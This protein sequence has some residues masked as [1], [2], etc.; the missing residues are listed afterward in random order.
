MKYKCSGVMISSHL[1]ILVTCER[2][3]A[4][5]RLKHYWAQGNAGFN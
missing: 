4:P 5:F 3:V 2:E 1:D